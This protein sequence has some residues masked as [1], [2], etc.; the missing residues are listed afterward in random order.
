MFL[1]LGSKFDFKEEEVSNSYPALTLPSSRWL[2]SFQE[3]RAL[4]DWR[5]QFWTRLCL[6]FREMSLKQRER[7][8]I[9]MLMSREN[10][11]KL[12]ESLSLQWLP[13]EFLWELTR[14][15]T[16]RVPF[17]LRNSDNFCIE[18]IITSNSSPFIIPYNLLT[19]RNQISPEKNGIRKKT[20]F[21][22]G[23]Y[24]W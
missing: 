12:R 7:H 17:R 13:S 22:E 24:S 10:N 2:L 20:S 19:S 6:L 21:N 16:C 1:T 5:I 18:A 14:N 4:Y 15:I 23:I 3:E 11:E 9:P 8:V